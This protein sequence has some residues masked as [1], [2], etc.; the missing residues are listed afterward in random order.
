MNDYATLGSRAWF[1]QLQY[2]VYLSH[3]AVS[4]ISLPVQRAMGSVIQTYA[5]KGLGTVLDWVDQRERLR[6]KI[7]RFIQA[8]TDEIA[9]TQNTSQGITAVA[10]SLRWKKRDRSLLFDGEFP[11]NVTPW[12]QA[13]RQYDLKVEWLPK[14]SH[15]TKILEQLEVALRKGVR[16]LSVSAVQF[17]TGFRMPIVEMG[18]LCRKHGCLVFIDAI[19]ACGALA[20]S[21]R[22]TNIDFLSCGG[23]KWLMGVEGTGF[24]YVRQNRIPLL[25]K[26][27]SSW[28]SHEDGLVFLFEGA[29]LLRYDRPIKENASFFEGGAP[30]AIGLVGLESAIDI[31]LQLGVSNIEKHILDYLKPL[32]QAFIEMGFRSQRVCDAESSIL[33]FLPPSHVSLPS[34]IEKL[35]TRGISLSSPD[36]L[37]RIAPHW[38]N[39]ISEHEVLLSGIQEAMETV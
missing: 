29:G 6:G 5:E 13:A 3:A 12:Q 22:D 33:S 31:L 11:S 36:G 17:Q 25:Q 15:P 27:L 4:P 14:P 1:P 38:P 26:N 21:V 32:E 7:A 8:D 37:L 30:N 34:L 23:H 2:E 35:D 20:M 16:L 39:N 18:N 28:L 10:Q 9:L 19:Q 24:L